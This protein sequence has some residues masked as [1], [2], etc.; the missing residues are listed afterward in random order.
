MFI[1]VE[2]IRDE[3]SRFLSRFDFDF[4]LVFVLIYFCFVFPQLIGD[5]IRVRYSCSLVEGGKVRKKIFKRKREVDRELKK[6]RES[7]AYMRMC[8]LER[9][10]E[11]DR[12]RN[13]RNRNNTYLQ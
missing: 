11:R 8:M 3:K 6:V 1:G 4:V 2:M 13:R 10:G 5:V 7:V 12:I 9:E